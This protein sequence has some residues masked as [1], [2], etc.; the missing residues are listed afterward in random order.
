MKNENESRRIRI[1]IPDGAA[2]VLRALHKRGFEAYVVGGCVRDSILGRVPDDWDITTSARPAEVK[3][4]FRRTV[5]TGIKHGTVTV[6]IGH[7][8]YEVTTYRIDGNYTD[9]RH[10]DSVQYTPSLLEDLKRRDFTIN[11]MAYSPETGI[12]DEFDGVGDLRR[13]MIRAVGNPV[14]RFEEDALRMMRA[15]RFAAQLGYQIE[16]ETKQAAEKLAPNLQRVSAERIHV[17]LDKLL[18]S[19]HPEE[20]R[21][22]YSLGL[23]DQFLPELSLCMTCEQNN[24]HHCYSVGEHILHAVMASRADLCLRLTLL[25]HDVA[26]PLVKTTDANGIDHFHGHAEKS[27]EMANRILRRLKYD[28]VMRTMV[29]KLVAWHDRDLGSTPAEVRHSIAGTGKDLFPLLLEVKQADVDAQSDYHR[30]QKNEQIGMWQRQYEKI[31]EEGDCLSLKDLAVKG[32]DLIQNG[33]NPGKS[34]GAVLEAML[35]DVLKEPS[36]NTKEYL[37]THLDSFRAATLIS[38]INAYARKGD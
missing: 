28:N 13:K 11:A 29:V 7:E 25:L 12:V 33:I 4:I 23:L 27:A 8:S 30:I 5:D 2:Q 9:G 19:P 32:K 37:L 24:P 6:L 1:D 20:L 22:V 15:V 26:K 18:T 17:E 3:D 21:E 36:H 31:L 10:P 38:T 34:L 35:E 14:H 16:E